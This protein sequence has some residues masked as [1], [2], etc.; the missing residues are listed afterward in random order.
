MRGPGTLDRAVGWSAGSEPADQV[1]AVAV[2]AMAEVGIDI[3]GARPQ[4]WTDAAIRTADVVVTMGCGDT[5]PFVP[6][7]R[8]EDWPLDD[9]AGQ[10]GRREPFPDEVRQAQ[11][12]LAALGYHARPIDGMNGPASREAVRRFQAVRGLPETGEIT[13]GLLAA[14]RAAL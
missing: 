8:Y 4:R 9:P 14:L 11:R 1:N 6:G 3:A 12:L 13:P 2:A 5:C 7:V 10:G